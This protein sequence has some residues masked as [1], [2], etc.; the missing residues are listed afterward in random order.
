VKNAEGL[1]MTHDDVMIPLGRAGG[2]EPR[3]AS[4][5]ST[6]C[7]STPW[8]MNR[9]GCRPAPLASYCARGVTETR[10]RG[11]VMAL[12]IDRS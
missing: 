10:R 9:I 1:S 8:T 2:R 12:S 7:S 5:G 3:S 6:R 11:G 4:A